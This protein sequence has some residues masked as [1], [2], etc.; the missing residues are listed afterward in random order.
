MGEKCT[1]H[2]LR[3]GRLD[4]E[5]NSPALAALFN[6]GWTVAASVVLDAGS[7][8]PVLNLIMKPPTLDHWVKRWAIVGSL[9]LNTATVASVAAYVLLGA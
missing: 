1:I 8:D 2:A 9:L 7:G 6:K 3:L 4:D 5:V